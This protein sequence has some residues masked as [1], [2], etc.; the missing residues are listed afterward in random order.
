[1]Y[2][3]YHKITIV[4]RKR[5]NLIINKKKVYR[6]CKELEVLRPQRKQK[7]EY[8]RKTAKKREIT[9]SNSLWEIDVKYGTSM[10][11]IDSST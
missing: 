5:F 3:G 6:L 1:M 10:V 7:A 9:M 11:K 2:Y 8:P 4:I